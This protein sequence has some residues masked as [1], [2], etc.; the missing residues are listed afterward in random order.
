MD[1]INTILR[2]KHSLDYSFQQAL[3]SQAAKSDPKNRMYFKSGKVK[4]NGHYEVSIED[5]DQ[6]SA[7]KTAKGDL[8]A[9]GT[10][11]H[12]QY[13][14]K[15]SGLAANNKANALKEKIKKLYQGI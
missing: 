4:I 5:L 10:D 7:L 14:V 15:V 8:F 2:L 6:Y 1:P 13:L 11:I 9:L 3:V 12:G